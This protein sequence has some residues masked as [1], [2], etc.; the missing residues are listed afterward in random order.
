VFLEKLDAQGWLDLFTNIKRGCSISDLAEFYAKC[1]VTSGVV[2]STV[3]GHELRFDVSDLGELL[4]VSSEGF[5][6]YVRKDKNV[7]GD[8]RL[9]ELTHKLVQ[10]PHLIESW[11]V[12]KGK[13][14]PL[15]QLLF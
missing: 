9:L 1:I 3:N 5:N 13:M 4:G 10:K 14:M 7:L 12:K 15:H 6:V 8:E 2:T 11:S